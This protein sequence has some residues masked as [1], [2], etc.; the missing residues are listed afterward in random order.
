MP[1]LIAILLLSL[2]MTACAT[3]PT[4]RSQLQLFAASQMDQMGVAAF[5]QIKE[6]TPTV[7]DPALQRY[8]SCI[9]DNIVR[10][11]PREYAGARWDVSVF[12][13]D[14]ANAFAL[15]GGK[16]GV[17]T[18][19][20]DVAKTPDQLAAVI[21][22]EIGHVIAEHGNERMSTTFATQAGLQIA[23]ALAGEAGGQHRQTAMALL[24]LGAQVG[25]ILPFS[26]A[27]ERESD[28]IGLELMAKAG[29]DPRAAVQLWQNMARQPGGQPPEFLSTHP[30]TPSRIE[31]LQEQMEPA[32]ALYQQARRQGRSPSC[33]APAGS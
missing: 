23:Q 14:S 31:N 1:R 10:A 13:D 33:R 28:Q 22:H 6:K 21:G 5:Q 18:G 29:F 32:R 11:L 20:L 9:T 8:V 27:Q 17:N 19:M 30:A 15:P 3:S 25:V 2:L 7:R 24:G 16:I 26:R 4:G 12:K